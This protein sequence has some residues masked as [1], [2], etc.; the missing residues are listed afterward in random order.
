MTRERIGEHL[1]RIAA[2]DARLKAMPQSQKQGGDV[3]YEA[4]WLY[5]D[6]LMS[7]LPKIHRDAVRK[8]QETK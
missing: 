2:I 4:L 7:Q 5:R 8:L 1:I 6:T 3:V